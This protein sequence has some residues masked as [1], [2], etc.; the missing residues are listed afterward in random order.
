MINIIS[1]VCYILISICVGKYDLFLGLACAIYIGH[2][3]GV[4]YYKAVKAEQNNK[5]LE[6]F[7]KDMFGVEEAE[8]KDGKLL[9]M[10]KDSEDEKD[11]E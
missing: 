1:I 5:A 8:K 6:V 11:E 3:L 9:S 4:Q 2:E 7:I 10:V